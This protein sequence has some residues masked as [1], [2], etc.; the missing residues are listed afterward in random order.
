MKE[1]P[2]CGPGHWKLFLMGSKFNNYSELR[3][4]PVEGEAL[5]MVFALESTRMFSLGNPNL[6]VETN[7]KPL[8]S[9]IGP[10]NLDDIKNP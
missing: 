7:H 3:Y 4:A 9:I 8:V 5:V 10:K 2:Y 1:A 6:T